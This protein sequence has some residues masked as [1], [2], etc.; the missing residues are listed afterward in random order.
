MVVVV[1]VIIGVCR[2]G[3]DGNF[4][5]TVGTVDT[6]STLCVNCSN[7]AKCDEGGLRALFVD[8]FCWRI[9]KEPRINPRP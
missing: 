4:K 2:Q 6:V 7:R 1:A 3:V 9:E 5:G 8:P